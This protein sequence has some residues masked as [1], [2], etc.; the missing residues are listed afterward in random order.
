[1]A[2]QP[3]R[4]FAERYGH[5]LHEQPCFRTRSLHHAAESEPGGRFRPG[6]VTRRPANANG[7]ERLNGQKTL[8]RG[9]RPDQ[10]TRM[11]RTRPE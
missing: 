8:R 5:W 3:I 4:C 11:L 9:V 7:H 1:M 6:G 10:H 2:T